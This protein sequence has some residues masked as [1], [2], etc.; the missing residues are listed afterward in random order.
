VSK[1][2]Y[3][4]AVSIRDLLVNSRFEVHFNAG[5]KSYVIHNIEGHM[6]LE[7]E[8]GNKCKLIYFVTDGKMISVIV[9]G[10]CKL[11]SWV[12]LNKWEKE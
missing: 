6:L 7:D 8:N 9:E 1:E 11:E 5:G 4:Y 2:L 3:L 12:L 10:E